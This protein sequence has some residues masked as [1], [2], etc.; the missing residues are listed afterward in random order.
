MRRRREAEHEDSCRG[1]PEAGERMRGIVLLGE[2]GAALARDLLTPAHQPR[3]APAAF[4]LTGERREA[5]RAVHGS[6]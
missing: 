3:A 6:P 4:D 1:I 5:P 2:G